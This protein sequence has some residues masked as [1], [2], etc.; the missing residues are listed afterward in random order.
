MSSEN[1]SQLVGDESCS[2]QCH[3]DHLSMQPSKLHIPL[4]LKMRFPQHVHEVVDATV[5]SM[6]VNSS[7]MAMVFSSRSP[8]CFNTC[9]TSG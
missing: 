1:I 2:V 8:V 5:L 4:L 9:D 7:Q 6:A 3:H